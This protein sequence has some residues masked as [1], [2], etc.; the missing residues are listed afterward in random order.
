[1]AERWRTADGALTRLS[2]D[3]YGGKFLLE[4]ARAAV[5]WNRVGDRMGELCYV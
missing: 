1:M 4:L 5:V 2:V 3:E